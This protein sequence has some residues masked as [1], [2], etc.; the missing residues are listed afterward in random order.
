MSK[1]LPAIDFTETLSSGLGAYNG[2]VG[3]WWV[4]KTRSAA[5]AAAY[6][7]IA[8]HVAQCAK[9]NGGLIIDYGCG[10]GHLLKRLVDVLPAWRFL[11]IDGSKVLLRDAEMWAQSKRNGRP[12]SLEFRRAKLP[13]FSVSTPKADIIVFTFPNIVTVPSDN[14]RFEKLFPKDRTL[15]GLLAMKQE[16]KGGD[17]ETLYDS[18]FMSRVVS[19]NLRLLLRTGGLCVRVDYSQAARPEL[20]RF[21]QLATRFEEGSLNAKQARIKPQKFFRLLYSRYYPSAVIRDVYEQT[22]DK[23]FLEGGYL[24]SLLKAL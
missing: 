18:L 6:K 7:N 10:P 12:A 5:H 13:D 20:A 3:Q 16:G 4:Q 9:G 15:A 23:D 17:V 11:G 24:V 21:D 22:E 1:I 8:S 2:P 14:R 19:R